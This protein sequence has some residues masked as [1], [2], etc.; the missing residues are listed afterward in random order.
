MQSIAAMLWTDKE[1]A[2]LNLKWNKRQQERRSKKENLNSWRKSPT[3]IIGHFGFIVS[4]K[5]DNMIE[6][7]QQQGHMT[8]QSG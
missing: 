4:D 2:P 1:N 3:R 7:V 6:K 5:K 8:Q